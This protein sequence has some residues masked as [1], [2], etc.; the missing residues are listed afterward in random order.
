MS[1]GAGFFGSYVRGR[2]SLYASI[3]RRRERLRKQQGGLRADQAEEFL[4][5]IGELKLAMA[6]LINV[7][8]SKGVVSEEELLAQAD[9]IDALDGEADGQFSGQVQPDG[10]VAPDQ[11]RARTNLDDLADAVDEADSAPE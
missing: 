2:D 6:T 5:D 10:K 4:N 3:E 7:L 1:G 8:I 9:I 11:P